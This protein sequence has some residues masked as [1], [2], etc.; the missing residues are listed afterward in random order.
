M[1]P[2]PLPELNSLLSAM[3][4]SLPAALAL[5]AGTL[6]VKFVLHRGLDLLADRTRLSR[7]DIEPARK[8]VN[9]LLTGLAVILLLSVFGFNLG[10]LWT[11]ISTI[12]ALI[13][14]GFVAVWSVLSNVSCT[15]IILIFRP[16]S[17]GDEIEFVGEQVKGRVA[18]LNFL[19]TTL[20]TDDGALIQ[21]PNNLFFQKSLRRRPG[22]GKR[23]LAEQLREQGKPA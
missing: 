18:D 12:L 23:S 20:R 3:L 4:A 13:A 8:V 5:I 1:N 2:L 14:I 7:A 17:I 16:F 9:W 21:I 11:M 10:G 22:E 15:F 6:L 19:Y